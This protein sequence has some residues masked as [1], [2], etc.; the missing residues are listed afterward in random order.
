[1][2]GNVFHVKYQVGDAEFIH[3]KVFNPLPHTGA[4]S[5]CQAIADG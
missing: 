4:P 5:E 1:M 3:A 2:A